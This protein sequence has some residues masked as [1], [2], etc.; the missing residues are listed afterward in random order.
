LVAAG[1]SPGAT[2]SHD[3]LSFTW[4]DVPPGTADNTA[5]DGQI[6]DAPGSGSKLGFLGGAAFGTPDVTG[7]VFVTYTDGSIERAP[8]SFG[9][10]YGDAPA[11]GNDTVATVPWNIQPGGAS[12]PAQVSV[13]YASI[14]LNPAKTVRYVTLPSSAETHGNLHVFALAIG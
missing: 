6:I 5:A 3:G 4:P 10:W 8:L 7:S 12:N 11:P 1:L 14:P 2:V 9:D 13:Y